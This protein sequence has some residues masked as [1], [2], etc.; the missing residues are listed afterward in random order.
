MP[1]DLQD[2]SSTTIGF[3]GLS[4]LASDVDDLIASATKRAAAARRRAAVGAAASSGSSSKQSD[5]RGEQT[6]F[7]ASPSPGSTRRWLWGA[8]AVLIVIWLIAL[9]S[10]SSGLSPVTPAS[11]RP[12]SGSGVGTPA[13]EHSPVSSSPSQGRMEELPPVGPDRVLDAAQI[14]Y[15]LSEDIRLDAARDV[16]SA[17]ADVDRFNS[18]INDFNSRCANYRYRRQVFESVQREVQSNRTSLQAEGVARFQR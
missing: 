9:A 3:A 14:R 4:N 11:S 2:P 17:D 18:M 7:I 1:S 12:T 10:N 5:Q 15:C 8:G 16:V 6:T 13:G